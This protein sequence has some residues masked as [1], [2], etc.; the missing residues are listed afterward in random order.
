MVR[1]LQSTS[2]VMP[3]AIMIVVLL[4]L[5]LL[6]MFR[7]SLNSF[8]PGQFMV[9]SLTI[10]NYQMAFTD[11]Y[12]RKVLLETILMAGLV[13]GA[14]IILGLPLAQFLS[15]TSA[16][17]KSILLFFVITPLFIGNAVRS[18]GWMIAFGQQGLV[19]ELS[20]FVGI[21]DAPVDIMFTPVAVFIGLVS[22]NLPF[23][24]L[25]IQSVLDGI[26]RSAEQAALSLGATKLTTWYLVTLPQA[27]PGVIAAS[28]L[29]FILAINAYAT[30]VLLGGPSFRMMAPVLADEILQQNNWPVGAALALLMISITVLLTLMISLRIS[31]SR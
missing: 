15:R 27:R 3:A 24:A 28:V 9:E 11:P 7:Y 25:T 12:Y 31:K 19:N 21:I 30:P 8:V 23:V 1:R 6:L 17:W 18:A 5:P 2:L 4:V 26:D 13:T 22:V 16:R 10:A 29:S 20:I 14:C